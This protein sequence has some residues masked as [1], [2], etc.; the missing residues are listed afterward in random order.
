[1]ILLNQLNYHKELK[2]E[3][4]LNEMEKE[5]EYNSD[6]VLKLDS[7]P[8]MTKNVMLNIRLVYKSREIN[9]EK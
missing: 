9:Y 4:E 6:L 2:T 1:M 3:E 7:R 8:R 5:V